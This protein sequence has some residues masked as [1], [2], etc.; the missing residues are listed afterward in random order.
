MVSLMNSQNIFKVVVI[1]I[2]AEI[3]TPQIVAARVIITEIMYDVPGSDSGREWIEVLNDSDAS[4]SIKNWRLLEGGTK[5]KI[6]AAAGGD[7]LAPHAYAVIADNPATF[8]VDWPNFSGQLFDSAFSLSGTGETL[9][10]FD[11]S[12]TLVTSSTYS[13]SGAGG[14][15]NSLNSTRGDS[16]VARKPTPGSAL[17][18]VS[19]SAPK[20]VA[21]TTSPKPATKKTKTASHSSLKNSDAASTDNTDVPDNAAPPQVSDN[22][23]VDVV[24]AP[25]AEVA[26]AG[27]SGGSTKYLWWGGAGVLALLGAG[28]AMYARSSSKDEWEIEESS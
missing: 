23:P 11:A 20:K 14:D 5:H 24:E 7:T 15:G 16:F 25:E 21:Q 12:S 4:V 19:I 13:G 28:V 2:V 22:A 26:A 18:D 3:F 27:E 10:L 8:R 6:T 1:I 9:S 17:S